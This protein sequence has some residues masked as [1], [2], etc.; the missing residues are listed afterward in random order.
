[1]DAQVVGQLERHLRLVLQDPARLEQG[2][3]GVGIVDP[4]DLL[5]AGHPVSPSQLHRVAEAT[6][7]GIVVGGHVNV[8][9]ARRAL[10]RVVDKLLGVGGRRF[11]R[12][13]HKCVS[14]LEDTQK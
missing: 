8:D 5:V 13:G 9:R 4:V 10:R 7:E 14:N 11:Q 6:N 12:D 2:E 3:A 1:M